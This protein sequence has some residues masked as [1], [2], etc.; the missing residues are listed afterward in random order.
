MWIYTDRGLISIVADRVNSD[1]VWIRSR[2]PEALL[3]LLNYH[4]S[5]RLGSVELKMFKD[6]KADYLYR[7]KATKTVFHQ[8]L[9]GYILPMTY[10]NFKDHV[11]KG[12]PKLSQVYYNVY[13]SS[14]D[15]EH[16]NEGISPVELTEVQYPGSSRS[17]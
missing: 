5:S 15:L 1:E 2:T 11:Q 17:S 10:T 6:E 14:V 7:F 9:A 12:N 13:A 8:I 16:I 4:D 3:P